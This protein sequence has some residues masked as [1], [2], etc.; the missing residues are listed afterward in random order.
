MADQA[1]RTI[2][3][4]KRGF[5]AFA[6]RAATAPLLLALAGGLGLLLVPEAA[7]AA[8]PAV[9]AEQAIAAQKEGLRSVILPRCR[10]DL[11]EIVVCGRRADRERVPFPNQHLP[12]ARGHLLPGEPMSTVAAL[13][14][15]TPPC[16]SAGAPRCGF[17][18]SFITAGIILFKVGKHLADPDSDPPPTPIGEEVTP[19]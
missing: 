18:I 8:P 12:G 2:G 11:E 3:P 10:P 13:N 14:A 16:N 15:D 9:T 5:P 7:G 6:F 17:S 19:P 1:A 4:T